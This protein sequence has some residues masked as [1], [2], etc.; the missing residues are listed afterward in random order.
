MN[1]YIGKIRVRT[2]ENK[3]EYLNA[4]KTKLSNNEEKYIIKNDFGDS[5]GESV[6]KIRKQYSNNKLEQEKNPSHIFVDELK[7]YSRLKTPYHNKNLKYYKDI[8]TR[9]LQI[10]QK[11]S[12]E[13]GFD[14]NIELIS[15]EESKPFYLNVIK[16]E[17]KY[18]IG[19]FERIYN[20][21]NKL[22]LP[23]KT[24]EHLS[25]LQGGL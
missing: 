19:S 17:E 18:P 11:R 15:K 6:I 5:I 25:K 10:A 21:P 16:M 2:A 9:L 1:G 14:G 20:N 12:I 7:N 3:I 22:F 23:D 4:F 8:G 24:K 13:L